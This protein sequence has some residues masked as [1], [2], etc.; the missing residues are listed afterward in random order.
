MESTWFH[1]IKCTNFFCLVFIFYDFVPKIKI[2]FFQ[3]DK[4]ILIRSVPS[5]SSWC[6]VYGL[7][8]SSW[9]CSLYNSMYKF[10][11][12]LTQN[13]PPKS[14]LLKIPKQLEESIIRF[15]CESFIYC[16]YVF[17][18]K[19]VFWPEGLQRVFGDWTALKEAYN[20]LAIKNIL[21]QKLGKLVKMWQTDTGWWYRQRE[22][23]KK[24]KMLK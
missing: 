8:A 17:Y 22:K 20:L 5:T 24:N 10:I 3:E 2:L 21:E 12:Y 13:F 14:L 19:I 6:K 7:S 1:K 15:H 16:I 4:I 23:S 11:L 9:H 18:F